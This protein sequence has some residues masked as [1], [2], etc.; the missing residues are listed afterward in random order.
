MLKISTHINACYLWYLSAL[1]LLTSMLAAQPLPSAYECEHNY[2]SDVQTFCE[3]QKLDEIDQQ[4]ARL[5]QET[6]SLL[7][8]SM[9]F[10]QQKYDHAYYDNYEMPYEAVKNSLIQSQVLWSQYRTSACDVIREMASRGTA[11]NIIERQC[12]QRHSKDR[13]EQLKHHYEEIRLDV[14]SLLEMPL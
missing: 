14:T 11:K 6:L 4:I 10:Y 9:I 5:Y 3:N 7:D 8:Q 2:S 12:Q 13:Y 1:I